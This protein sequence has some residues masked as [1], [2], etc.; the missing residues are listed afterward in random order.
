MDDAATALGLTRQTQP[1]ENMLIPLMPHQL[2][3]VAW[4]V[5]REKVSFC[6]HFFFEESTC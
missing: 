5:E 3:G 4:M 2:I 1:V 6:F